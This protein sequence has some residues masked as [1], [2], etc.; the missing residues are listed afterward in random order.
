MLKK[1]ETYKKNHGNLTGIEFIVTE[2]I[3]K[4]SSGLP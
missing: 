4:A 1:Y 3:T 2:Y